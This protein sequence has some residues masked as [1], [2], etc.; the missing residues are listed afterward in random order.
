RQLIESG[1]G[2][3]FA[4]DAH[5]LPGRKYKMRQAFEKLRH[6][7]GSGLVER[8]QQNARLIINGKNTVK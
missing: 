2:Y 3:I 5:D 7:F 4:S 6:E 8:Y 1:Q